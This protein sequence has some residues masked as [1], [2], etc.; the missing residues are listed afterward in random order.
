[1]YVDVMIETGS[2]FNRTAGSAVL[3]RWTCFF[4]S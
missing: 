1:M 3:S 2:G 4:V